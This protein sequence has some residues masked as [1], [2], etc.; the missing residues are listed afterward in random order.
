MQTFRIN[1]LGERQEVR[2]TPHKGFQF[3]HARVL[4]EDMK[5]QQLYE[6]TKIAKGIIYY[7][8]IRLDTDGRG[9]VI[10]GADMCEY[11]D[12]PRWIQRAA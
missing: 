3:F 12:F 7:R 6:I 2:Y 10:G 9:I 1:Y 5:S 4:T 8:P 11:N